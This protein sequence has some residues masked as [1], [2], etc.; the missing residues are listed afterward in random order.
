MYVYMYVSMYRSVLKVK[1]Y[2]C[3]YRDSHVA[4]VTD[5]IS[6]Y[7]KSNAGFENMPQIAVGTPAV[8]EV[9]MYA[10]MYICMHYCMCLS[11]ALF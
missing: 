6:Y 1:T 4:I 2:V 10:C 5:Q 8:L 7:L 11:Y 9:C 3:M